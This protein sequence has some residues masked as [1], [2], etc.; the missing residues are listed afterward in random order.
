MQYSG[1]I[2]PR[3]DTGGFAGIPARIRE[4]CASGKYDAV[5]LFLIDGFGWRFFERFQDVLFLKRLTK[6]G[7]VEKLTAQFPSTTA[8]HLTTVHTGLPVGQSGVYEWFYYEPQVDRIIAPLLFSYAGDQDRDTLTGVIKPRSLYPKQT[9]Y[10]GLDTLGI[11]SHVFG[12]HDY[13]PSPYS[14]AVM[15]GAK[16]NS[17]RTL[18]EALV[19]L[20]KL[21]ETQT[22]STYVH[23]YFDKIDGICHAYGPAALQTEAELEAFLLIMEYFFPRIFTGQKRVLFL[24]TAD[25]G[26]SEVDPKTA[27]FLNKDKRFKGVERFIKTN[28]NRELLVPAGSARDMFLYVKDELLEET[29]EFLAKRLEGKAE[30]VKTEWLI[31]NGYFGPE[32]SPRFRARVG[33]LV[34]LPHRYESIWWYEKDRFEQRFY[35]HHGGLTPQ[36]MEIPFIALEI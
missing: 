23:F 5:V 29:Q 1:F 8:A 26:A 20:G 14:N 6:S 31:K 9:L 11:D 34:I 27:I 13:T 4:F 18:A 36:E 33:N 19:N 12:A 35:G 7:N 22:N 24:M 16:L 30:V 15:K 17:F 21:L 2:K 10:Q 3:Y 28:R 32:I 25:H